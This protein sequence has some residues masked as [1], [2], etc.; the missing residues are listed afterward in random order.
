M[1]A[2]N[3]DYNRLIELNQK[4]NNNNATSLEKDEYML[5]LFNNGS[6]SK[7]QYDKYVS[8]K[9]AKSEEIIK[10]ALAIGGF[11]LVAYLVSK[12]FEKDK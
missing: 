11:I 10:A 2:N 1:A 4:I 8:D 6:I 12:L 7:E 5:A 9:S 3:L